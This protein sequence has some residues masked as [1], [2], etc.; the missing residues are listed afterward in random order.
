MRLHR[1]A[2]L[3][4]ALSPAANPATLHVSPDGT[5]SDGMSWQTAFPTIGEAIVASSTGDE[6]WIES[7]TYVE[8][9]T[10]FWGRPYSERD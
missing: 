10:G 3:L 2:T 7:A 5:G 6:V 4:L 1:I 8:N 9:V